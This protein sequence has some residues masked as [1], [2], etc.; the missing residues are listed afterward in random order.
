MAKLTDEERE[1]LNA[2]MAIILANTPHGASWQINPQNYHGSPGHDVTYFTSIARNQHSWIRGE[3]FADRI[4]GALDREEDE[5]V[6][7]AKARADRAAVLRRELAA[8]GEV[9]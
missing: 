4:Q 6:D 7:P 3:T 5:R 9:A 2:A 1:T 8:L